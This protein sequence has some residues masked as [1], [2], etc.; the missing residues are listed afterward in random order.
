MEGNT[1]PPK[2]APEKQN[3]KRVWLLFLYFLI[4]SAASFVFVHLLL[5]KPVV[6]IT[7]PAASST[8]ATAAPD[9]AP[10]P[11]P[12]PADAALLPDGFVYVSDIIPDAQIDIRYYSAY[13]FVGT[14]IDGY[15]APQAIL[16]KEAALA[17]KTAST[18]LAKQGYG[19]KIFDA[20]R[21]LRAVDHFV[22]WSQDLTDTKMKAVFYPN[23]DKSALFNQGFIA[24]KSGHSRGS[25]ADLTLV[26]LI[27][28]QEV[29]MG[30]SFDFFGEIS[31]HGTQLITNQQT[32][33]R[34]ILRDAMAAA[35]FAPY[36]KEWWH[37][38][39][40][41]E[42]YPDQYFDFVIR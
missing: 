14:R 28:G 17:L 16:T 6:P 26:H 35:G 27:S 21:P 29:D 5:P 13:N 23:L 3:Y 25:T 40:Q 11:T 41:N 4:L 42:P 24:R 18:I 7:S 32:Q 10:V 1:M 12:A 31:H 34:N 15:E 33:S 22:S 39:L 30:S 38:C 20:Y 9:S 8:T 2:Q 37:Y 19:I 36:S